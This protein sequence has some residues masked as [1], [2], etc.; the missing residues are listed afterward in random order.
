MEKQIFEL[1]APF[2]FFGFCYLNRKNLSMWI[3]RPTPRLLTV[4]EFE[5]QGREET[6]KAL[7]ELRQYCSSPK[8]NAWKAVTRLESPKRYRIMARIRDI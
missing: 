8:C 5:E 2:Y 6:K 4:D 7:K 3:H 1:K